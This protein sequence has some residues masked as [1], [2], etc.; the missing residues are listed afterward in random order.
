MN[1]L[2]KKPL[3]ALFIASALFLVAGVVNFTG[4]TNAS[5]IGAPGDCAKYVDNQI[6][7]SVDNPTTVYEKLQHGL[8][9]ENVIDFD[10][11]IYFF[12]TRVMDSRAVSI[13]DDNNPN[14]GKTAYPHG[15]A[16]FCRFD[17]R[18]DTTNNYEE[19][20]IPVDI[21]VTNGGGKQVGTFAHTLDVMCDMQTGHVCQLYENETDHEKQAGNTPA[22]LGRNP[23]KLLSLLK[24]GL[25]NEAA[26]KVDNGRVD[27]KIVYTD[28]DDRLG[29]PENGTFMRSSTILDAQGTFHA[30]GA[31]GQ[32]PTKET[33]RTSSGGVAP[34]AYKPGAKALPKTGSS[35]LI[36]SSSALVIVGGYIAYVVIKRRKRA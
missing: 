6:K 30:E 3:K 34:A 5:A 10:K 17:V 32:T 1:R 19:Y 26:K 14:K 18:H 33:T 35:V 2:N 31:N 29:I 28:K 27:V 4:L 20:Q 12:A 15:T 11:P 9:N 36:M 7:Y 13:D 22:E 8:S 23:L 21:V 25:S 16:Q 24:E